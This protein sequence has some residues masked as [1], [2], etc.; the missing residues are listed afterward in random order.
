[1]TGGIGQS[2]PRSQVL[3]AALPAPRTV[4]QIAREMGLA[5]QSVQR[6]ASKLVEKVV[7]RARFERATPSFGESSSTEAKRP[8]PQEIPESPVSTENGRK[9]R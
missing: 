7:T 1:M 2:G 3:A 5:L 6:T 8:E 4:S 9:P